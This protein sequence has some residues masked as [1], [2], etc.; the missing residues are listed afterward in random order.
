MDKVFFGSLKKIYLSFGS[1]EKEDARTSLVRYNKSLWFA[2]IL[3]NLSYEI[4]Y[5]RY[6]KM[7]RKAKGA[8]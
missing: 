8:K 5:E 7:L 1:L 4:F 3:G 6:A 2:P